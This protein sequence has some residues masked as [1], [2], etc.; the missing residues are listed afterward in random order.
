[1]CEKAFFKHSH[2]K[3]K[4]HNRTGFL[5]LGTFEAGNSLLQETALCIFGCLD[6]SLVYTH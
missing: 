5:N 2:N 3:P 6:A 4:T 1:M